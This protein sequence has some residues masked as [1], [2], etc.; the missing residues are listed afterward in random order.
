[1]VDR[2]AQRRQDLIRVDPQG[3]V[4]RLPGPAWFT[5]M[6]TGAPTPCPTL[7]A[8]R[9]TAQR[10]QGLIRASTLKGPAARRR[11]GHH[12]PGAI[13]MSRRR[14]TPIDGPGCNISA[15]AH[16]LWRQCCAM[17]HQGYADDDESL[18]WV[19]LELH[20]ELGLKPWHP[21]V[22]DVGSVGARRPV[23]PEGLADGARDPP[24]ARRGDVNSTANLAARSRVVQDEPH[25]PRRR[26]GGPTMRPNSR[27]RTRRLS[28]LRPLRAPCWCT[29][30]M[31][32]S[33]ICTVAS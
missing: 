5:G 7:T 28:C 16:E 11:L 20:R 22:I 23:A 4:P 9:L 31:D 3:P 13:S 2:A 15:R 8:Q 29:R 1:M 21:L 12:R 19:V 10:R 17:I 24:P 30:T 33:I 14:R 32:V 26:W 25:R 6:G 18:M 27:V